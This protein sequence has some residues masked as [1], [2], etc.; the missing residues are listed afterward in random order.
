[1]KD[2]TFGYRFLTI[3][4]AGPILVAFANEHFEPMNNGK[5]QLKC[6]IDKDVVGTYTFEEFKKND[7]YIRQL[8]PSS[9]G[10]Y[11]TDESDFVDT[12]KSFADVFPNME[13]GKLY[14]VDDEA[15]FIGEVKDN[16]T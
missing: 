6:W 16:V 15:Y 2:E 1:M 4:S 3:D 10:E 12:D 7:E 9:R 14:Y 11:V 13:Q 5:M 8:K